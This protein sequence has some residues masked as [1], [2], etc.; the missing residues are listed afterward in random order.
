M[1]QILVMMA[2]VVLVGCGK[3]DEEKYAESRTATAEAFAEKYG[4]MF[5]G[6]LH[7]VQTTPEPSSEPHVA[8]SDDEK[9]IADAIVEKRVRDMLEMP[10][11]ELTEA[12]LEKVLVLKWDSKITDEGLK[13]VAKLK[14]LESLILRTTEI[15][16]EGL[17]E[18][19]KLEKLEE[20]SLYTTQITDAGLKEVTKL[21]NLKTLGLGKTKITDEGLKELA[22]LKNLEELGLSATQITDVGL[23]E[24]AK[25]QNLEELFLNDTKI[26]DEGLKEVA[27]LQKLETLWLFDT[28]VTAEGVAELK[29]ALPNCKF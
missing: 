2:A 16:D 19:A 9:L 15:T 1:K 17:K 25:L 6:G 5:E 27:K 29:K 23:K 12:D 4:A 7:E 26:T 22:K 24:V 21:Q 14:N 20:L 3:S 10:E 13:D 18:V 11:G 28:Q 8:L